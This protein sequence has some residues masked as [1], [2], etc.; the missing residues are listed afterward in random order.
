MFD[1][2]RGEGSP[3]TTSVPAEVTLADGEMT[4]GKFTI[5][6]GRSLQ[7]V[8]N[9]DIQFLDFETFAGE[10]SL[11][12]KSLLRTVRVIEV[13]DQPALKTRTR[14]A[15]GFDPYAVLGLNRGASWDDIRQAYLTLT[16]AYHPDRYASVELPPE[17]REYLASTFARIS[18][19]Y[20]AL[21]EPREAAKQANAERAKPIFTSPQRF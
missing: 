11:I 4:K 14:D 16:K 3:Q 18:A 19:A 13:P 6:G 10:R 8:L 9:S 5:K 2:S 21:E 12:A 7:D 17:V 20:A 15:G 1:R